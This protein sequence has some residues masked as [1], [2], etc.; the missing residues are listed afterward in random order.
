MAAIGEWGRGKVML[1]K[2][3][4]FMNVS[5]EA[6]LEVRRTHPFAPEDLVV[7]HD[8]I[9]LALG[10]TRWVWARG[11]AGHNG[12]TSI[13]LSLGTNSFFRLRGGVGRPPPGILPADYVLE[14]FSVDEKA[15][16]EEM[17]DRAAQSIGDFLKGGIQYVQQKYH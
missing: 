16:V 14:E 15:I 4:N 6:L 11:S 7:V 3:T 1:V 8:D 2:P 17:V 10:K 9:D 5:G 12:V 13:A